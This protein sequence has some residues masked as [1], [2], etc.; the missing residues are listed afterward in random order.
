VGTCGLEGSATQGDTYVRLDGASGSEV[1]ANDD[2]C[3]GRGS[4][5]SYTAP[6]DGTLR[7]RAGCYHDTACG[8]T[9]A[10]TLQ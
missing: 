2:A 8:G 6:T 3:G 1:A 7:I 9:V 4:S 10:W 5:L